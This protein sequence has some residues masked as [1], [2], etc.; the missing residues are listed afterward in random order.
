MAAKGAYKRKMFTGTREQEDTSQI[1]K[2]TSR[3]KPKVVEQDNNQKA[4][5]L[6]SINNNRQP[7]N[8]DDIKEFKRALRYFEPTVWEQPRGMKWCSEKDHWVKA[9]KDYFSLK[10]DTRDGFHPICKE[11]RAAYAR[12]VYATSLDREVRPYT[13]NLAA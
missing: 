8:R 4:V 7:M 13:R 9:S 10:A 3:V 1:D 12:H 11:C 5:I 6:Q 2:I